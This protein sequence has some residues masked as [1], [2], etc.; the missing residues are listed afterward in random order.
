[1]TPAD[2][3][4]QHQQLCDEIY[5]LALEENRF[6]KQNQRIPDAP[7]RE[8]KQALLARLEISLAALKTMNVSLSIEGPLDSGLE[9]SA[10]E[11]ARARVMQILH[12]DRENEQLLFRY[13]LGNGPKPTIPTPPPSHLQRLYEK[14]S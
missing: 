2:T 12:L 4:H 13:S 14:K 11:K 6:L 7:F 8:R 10:V 1:M 3:L 9:K 5:Q